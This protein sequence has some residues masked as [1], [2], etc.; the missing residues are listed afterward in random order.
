MYYKQKGLTRR[1][2]KSRF[3]RK[4]QPENF[5]EKTN[6]AKKSKIQARQTALTDPHFS[7]SRPPTLRR[8]ILTEKTEFFIELLL[9]PVK[10]EKTCLIFANYNTRH[11]LCQYIFQLFLKKLHT[12]SF[13]NK[14][15]QNGK[16]NSQREIFSKKGEK[17]YDKG[18]F[19]KNDRFE[20]HRQ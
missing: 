13:A 2:R 20:R 10:N 7:I 19:E 16:N 5:T 4:Q 3:I 15:T 18:M 14:L 9:H 1:C 17:F 6:P 12:C 11:A 8:R